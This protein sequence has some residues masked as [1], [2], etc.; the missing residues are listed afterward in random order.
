MGQDRRAMLSTGLAAV[1]AEFG[2]PPDPNLQIEERQLVLSPFPPSYRGSV[3]DGAAS[4]RLPIRPTPFDQ[5]GDEHLPAW[6][7]SLPAQSTVYLTLGTS[8]LF[9]ARPSIMRAFIDGLANEPLNLIVT[10]GRNNDPADFGPVPSNVRIERYIPQTLL[11]PRCDLVVCHAGSG[12]VMAAL[13]H[14]L[15]LVLVPIGADQPQNARRCDALGLATVLEVDR[16]DPT[17][18]R[19]AVLNVL[20]DPSY[21]QHA[22]MVRAEIE[23]LP[24]PEQAV[25]YLERLAAH[26]DPISGRHSYDNR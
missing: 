8:S 1:L 12:T 21:R 22:E 7:G 10:V 2:L 17:V 13:V 15:P 20:A 16:L 23:A 14:G 4:P 11:F 19:A 9:N 6:S 24:G 18:A 26:Q 5:S 3:P 25:I